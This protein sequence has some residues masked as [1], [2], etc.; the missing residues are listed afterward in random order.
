MGVASEQKTTM[1][2]TI[3]RTQNIMWTNDG[4]GD[5]FGLARL[6]V[7]PHSVIITCVYYRGPPGHSPSQILGTFSRS[8]Q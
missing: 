3:Q 8:T 1:G 6:L 4:T 7:V 5:N 2:L